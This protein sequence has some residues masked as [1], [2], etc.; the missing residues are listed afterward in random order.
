MISGNMKIKGTKAV[1]N[2]TEP[3]KNMLMNRTTN[4]SVTTAPTMDF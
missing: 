1:V 4:K 3:V 2:I